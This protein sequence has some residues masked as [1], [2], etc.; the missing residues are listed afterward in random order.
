ML[1]QVLRDLGTWIDA[2][3]W[4]SVLAWRIAG[5]V[6]AI[7][8]GLR[9]LLLDAAT[10]IAANPGV[11]V[12]AQAVATAAILLVVMRNRRDSRM[13]EVP[14]PPIEPVKAVAPADSDTGAVASAEARRQERRCRQL[15]AALRAEIGLA[16]DAAATRHEAVNRLDREIKNSIAL[17]KI[18]DLAPLRF[19]TLGVTEGVAFRALGA[20]IGLLPPALIGSAVKFYNLVAEQGRVIASA[21]TVQQQIWVLQES[22]PRLRLDGAVA[23]AQLERFERAGYD[24][25]ADLDL[26]A[27]EL[28]ALKQRAEFVPERPTVLRDVSS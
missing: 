15:V 18:I 16:L 24:A 20:E 21:K 8:L 19:T 7:L 10:W 9:D 1:D 12:W 25:D 27:D 22:L 23:A 11:A 4:L 26:P 5:V 13:R 17:G 3:A 14:L 2:H 6:A 28:A